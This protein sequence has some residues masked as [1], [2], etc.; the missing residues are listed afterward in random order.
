MVEEGSV[1]NAAVTKFG[2]CPSVDLI[3][4][5]CMYNTIQVL[6]SDR[7]P[8]SRFLRSGPQ[9]NV[10]DIQSGAGRCDKREGTVEAS[11]LCLLL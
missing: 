7:P 6:Y 8:L 10:A 3:D 4:A 9:H 2:H 5:Y 11:L 1:T